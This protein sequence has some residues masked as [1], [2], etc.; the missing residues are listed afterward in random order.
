QQK[1]NAQL[2][3]CLPS[4]LIP[5]DMMS[6]P[7]WNSH[8]KLFLDERA[9]RI[10][11]LIKHYT[12]EATTEIISRHGHQ[13]E[14]SH[15]IYTPVKPRLKD[16]I[17][18]GTV[19]IGER[20]FIR[21]HPARSA[22]IVDGDTVEFEGKLLPINTWGQQITGWISINIYNYVVLERTGQSLEK[23]REQHV[24]V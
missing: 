1:S 5:L 8:F 18:D 15:S 24:L 9:E 17:A 7:T 16:M 3:S 2:A 6:D 13:S 21:K 10:F 4:H 22:T 12:I 19:S 23:L 11:D 14:T 20:V